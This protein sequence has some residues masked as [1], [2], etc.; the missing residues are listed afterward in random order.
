MGAMASRRRSWRGFKNSVAAKMVWVNELR[1][2]VLDCGSPLPL[3]VARLVAEKR[4]RA[5]AVQN[6]AESPAAFKTRPHFLLNR[7]QEV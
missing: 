4:Q 1:V 6:L 2:S 3:G 7:S 5:A